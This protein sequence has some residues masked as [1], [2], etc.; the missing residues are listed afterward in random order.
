MIIKISS[1][2]YAN[3][4]RRIDRFNVT[5]SRYNGI[6]SNLVSCLTLVKRWT[7]TKTNTR[8]EHLLAFL[9]LFR[10][11]ESAFI[12]HIL[13]EILNLRNSLAADGE[14]NTLKKST[15]T[16]IN[17]KETLSA[18]KSSTKNITIKCESNTRI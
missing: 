7:N 12:C 15:N 4:F 6:T 18:R 8:S 3:T 14:T 2:I 13:G 10:T 16:N 11:N 9:I 5:S 17:R 1:V